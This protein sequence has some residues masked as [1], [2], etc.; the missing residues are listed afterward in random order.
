MDGEKG[1]CEEKWQLKCAEARKL[2][3]VDRKESKNSWCELQEWIEHNE[4]KTDQVGGSD[5]VHP[6]T[7]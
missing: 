1:E 7:A 3:K 5:G 4:N 6:E 2:R